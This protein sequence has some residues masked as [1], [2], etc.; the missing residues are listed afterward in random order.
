MA[1]NS[2]KIE[3]DETVIRKSRASLMTDMLITKQ[4]TLTLTDRRLIFQP[5]VWSVSPEKVETVEL[6]LG[7]ITDIAAIKADTSNLLAGSLRRRLQIVHGDEAEEYII[8]GLDGWVDS[9][10]DAA[11]QAGGQ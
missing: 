11:G 10:R 4:G 6:E 3:P 9:I 8:R 7:E 5:S 2:I 1:M